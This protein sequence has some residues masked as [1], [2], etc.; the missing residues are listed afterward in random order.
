MKKHKRQRETK[1]EIH[2]AETRSG[3]GMWPW[4]AGAGGFVLALFAYGPSLNG[5]FVLDDRALPFMTPGYETQPLSVWLTGTRQLLMFTYWL[6]YRMSELNPGIYHFTNVVLHSL[7]AFVLALVAARFLTWSGVGGKARSTLAAFAGALFLLHPIQTE[8]VA[9]VASRSEVLSVLL[10]LTAFALWL[11]QD[12][13]P[14]SLARTVLRSVVIVL[15]FGAAVLTKEHTVML[16][17]LVPL[18]DIFW[19]RG[20]WRRNR[21]LYSLFAVGAV[22]GAVVIRNVLRGANTAGFN[23][24]EM[25]PATYFF[26]QCRVIWMYV[27]LFLLPF[28]L[29]ADPDLALSRSL[30]EPGA[31]VGLIALLALAIAAWIYRARFPLGSFGVFV[32]LLL[33]APTSSFMPIHDVYAERRLYLP[34]LG[35]A[36]IALELLR[37]VDFRTMKWI[38]IGLAAFYFVLTY[39]RS[40]VWASPLALWTDTA[41]KSPKKVR[42]RFQLA[43]AY[44]EQG[45]CRQA[46]QH[47]QAASQLDQPTYD[48]LADWALALDCAGRTAEAIPVARRAA[49]IENS[50]HARSTLGMY[51]A[52]TGELQAAL[53]EL[54]AAEKIDPRYEMTYVYRGTIAERAGDRVTAAN[55]YRKALAINPRNEAAQSALARAT[56]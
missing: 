12:E 30:W 18:T 1:P 51:Y 55:E 42:P 35:L 32:F 3:V 52:K 49:D 36:L 38:A 13:E 7:G 27:R 19:E 28:G 40:Q 11:Y 22:F 41:A 23:L 48:L 39:Q 26:T 37:R 14:A 6:N 44:Y 20:G 34:F 4:A 25:P 10:F 54:A 17:L 33:L 50:A 9:Y 5:A 8:S 47:Y 15:L 56:Q 29:N 24:A 16:V 46:A 53:L 45:D 2:A 31:I 21:I 43:F